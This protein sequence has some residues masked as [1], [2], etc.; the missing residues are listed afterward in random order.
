MKFDSMMEIIRERLFVSHSSS[1]QGNVTIEYTIR[2]NEDRLT[3]LF[4]IFDKMLPNLRVRDEHDGNLAMMPTKYVLL[5]LEDFVGKSDDSQ[6]TILNDTIEKINQGHL[7]IIW[8]KI[9]KNNSFSKNEI[10]AITLHY[11][12][13]AESGSDNPLLSIGVKNKP[14]PLYYTLY[15]PDD[16]DFGFQRYTTLS[17]DG[18]KISDTAPDF[19]DS[20]MTSN[21]KLLRI[22]SK[23]KSNFV[24]FYSFIPTMRATAASLFGF[25]TLFTLGMI[26]NIA[27]V[28][29]FIQ[30][31]L[32]NVLQIDLL[33]KNTEI[34]IFLIAGSLI[35][36]RLTN[37][38]SIRLAHTKLYMIPVFLGFVMFVW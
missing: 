13:R 30:P 37:N 34:G 21:S 19:V 38:D 33:T 1:E 31:T 7:Y 26:A 10:R 32:S 23:S 24:L 35:L 5:L 15:K 36:P 20:T 17:S 14:H 4:F 27:H 16:Y 28:L 22:N 6:K 8:V 11:S 25:V 2:S 3:N 12:S 18:I 29:I 9:P